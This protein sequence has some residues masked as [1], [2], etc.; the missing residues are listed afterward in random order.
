VLRPDSFP[1]KSRGDF[2]GGRLV[3]YPTISFDIGRFNEG[4][5]KLGRQKKPRQLL[6]GL[7]GWPL[8]AAKA[9]L[10]RSNIPAM[11]GLGGVG[12]GRMWG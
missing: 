8:N 5:G 1:T 9:T 11:G 10:L 4:G 7:R 12:N 6:A 2:W 3:G